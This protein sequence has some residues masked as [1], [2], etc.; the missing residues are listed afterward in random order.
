MG[1][2]RP[3]I[4][5]MLMTRAGSSAEPAARSNGRRNFV[6]WNTPCTFRSSTR[7]HEASSCSSRGTPQ[8]APALLTST[9]MVSWRSATHSPNRRHPCSLERS[10]VVPVAVPNSQSS[11]TV[12]CTAGSLRDVTITS[13]PLAAKPRAIM[14][15]MPLVPPVTTTVRPTTE[16]SSSAGVGP[17]AGVVSIGMCLHG[18]ELRPERTVAAPRAT[19]D[20]VSGPQGPQRSSQNRSVLTTSI[21]GCDHT[22]SS[23]E[24]IWSSAA[25][26]LFDTAE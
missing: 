24:S 11:S 4:D 15:P 12:A 21:S 7:F 19:P 16:K 22:K 23:T 20:P 26:G 14:A 3:F 8:V 1:G 5:P 2:S 9:S 10:D 17:V 25:P 6:V 13:A 18:F